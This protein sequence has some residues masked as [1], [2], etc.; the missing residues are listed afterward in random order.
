MQVFVIKKIG[1]F[2]LDLQFVNQKN[3]GLMIFI[4]KKT[5][6][7]VYN[8]KYWSIINYNYAAFLPQTIAIQDVRPIEDNNITPI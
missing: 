2:S 8:P 3:A 6:C 5:Y 1:S 4:R 7:N